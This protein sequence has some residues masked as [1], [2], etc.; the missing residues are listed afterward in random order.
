[1]GNV[2]SA[3]DAAELAAIVPDVILAAGTYGVLLQAKRT[4]SALHE[5]GFSRD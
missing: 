5:S 2:D 1:L 3:S 4:G